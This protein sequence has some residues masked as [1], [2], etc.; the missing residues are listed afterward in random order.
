[1]ESLS[2]AFTMDLVML[3]STVKRIKKWF[4]WGMELFDVA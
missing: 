2:Q 1:M 4:G 3:L